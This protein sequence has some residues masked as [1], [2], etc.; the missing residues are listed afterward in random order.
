MIEEPHDEAASAEE[1]LRQARKTFDD[2][3]DVL[4]SG[5]SELKNSTDP[6]ARAFSQTLT[7]FWKSVLYVQDRRVDLDRLQRALN[8]AANGYAIDLDAAEREVG[9]RLACL[10]AAGD[11]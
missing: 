11:D 8:G 10:A 9:R 7:A 5:I 6:K 2:I 4:Q 1:F 3:H